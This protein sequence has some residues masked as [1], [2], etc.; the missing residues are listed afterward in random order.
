MKG[1]NSISKKILKPKKL[2]Y[3]LVIVFEAKSTDLKKRVWFNGWK[4]FTLAKRKG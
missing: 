1:S 4:F 3:Q 2:I